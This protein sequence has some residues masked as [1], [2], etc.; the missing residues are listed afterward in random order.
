MPELAEYSQKLL[1][2][3]VRGRYLD[4]LSKLTSVFSELHQA[5]VENVLT[6]KAHVE[7][8]QHLESFT[9]Q[10]GVDALDIITLLKYLIYWFIPGEKYLSGLV[11]ADPD[12]SQALQIL[13]GLGVRTNLQLLQQGLTPQERKAL[14]EASGLPEQVVLDLVN[15]A[16]LSRLPWASKATISNL[17]GAGYSSLSQLANADPEKLYADF[18]NYGQSIGKNLKLG[19]EIEN[20]YR[21]AKIVPQLVQLE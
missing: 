21:I 19:N 15:R 3:D 11:R 5:G 6:L 7:S 14:A 13:A 18:Y 4:Y 17:I 1:G 9:Q 2:G 12:I 8:R 10:S 20:S 16:D